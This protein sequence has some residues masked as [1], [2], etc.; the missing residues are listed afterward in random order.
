MSDATDATEATDATDDQVYHDDPSR[1]FVPVTINDSEGSSCAN[2]VPTLSTSSGEGTDAT[3]EATPFYLEATRDGGVAY[4]G[5]L[6]GDVIDYRE[7]R[8]LHLQ[9]GL[10]DDQKTNLSRLE[11]KL[12]HPP[13][14]DEENSSPLRAFYRWSCETAAIVRE[15]ENGR[16][17]RTCVV[18]EDM[19]AG[20]VKVVGEHTFSPGDAV[21]LVLADATDA[22]EFPSRVAWVR[23]DAF[24]L[25]FA[26][27]ARREANAG[28]AA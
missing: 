1:D 8:A 18:I 11:D 21:D 4:E 12:R 2:R 19:S 16:P 28:R 23:G 24:G 7:L 26:G 3:G 6:L 17:R 13:K 10:Q 25:M 15:P 5:D 27:A 22:V 14:A 9:G 20:G